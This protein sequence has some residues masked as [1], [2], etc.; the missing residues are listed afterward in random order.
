[1]DMTRWA[2]LAG[3]GFAAGLLMLAVGLLPPAPPRLA[4]ALARLA[5]TPAEPPE[6]GGLTGRPGRWLATHTPPA[7]PLAIPASDLR[8]LAVDPDHFHLAR[9]SLAGSGLLVPGLLWT[10][11]AAVGLDI[12]PELPVAGCFALAIALWLTANATIRSRAAAKRADFRAGLAAYLDL[13]ALERAGAGSPI[14]AMESAADIGAGPVF[15]RIRTQLTHAARAGTSPYA[16]LAGLADDLGVP[17]LQDLADIT[18]TAADG[19]AIYMT[20]LAK[21]RSLRAAVRADD[22][23]AANAASERLVF[24]VVLLGIAFLLLL[25]Y[26]ALVRLLTVG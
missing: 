24:P 1:M 12:E 3:G 11:A 18:A 8:L 16:A 25:F 15:T 21:S 23:A 6:R 5:A 19:A 2:L 26:P 14:E 7:G 9:A 22:Q 4:A 10:V 20:L 17:E 13:V